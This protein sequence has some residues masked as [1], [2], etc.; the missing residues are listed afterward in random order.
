MD[1]RD[2]SENPKL[3]PEDA[4]AVD[5]WIDGQ[6]PEPG[7]DRSRALRDLLAALDTA[8]TMGDRDARVRSTLD[9]LQPDELSLHPDL[10]EAI[11]GRMLGT[12]TPA[13]LRGQSDG[14]EEIGALL[15]S[16]SAPPG[17]DAASKVARVDR[18]MSRIERD[19]SEPSISDLRQIAEA[20]GVPMSLLFAHASAPSGE[21]GYIVRAGARRPMGSGEE[22]MIEAF[23]PKNRGQSSGTPQIDL[24]EVR[25][26]LL[27]YDRSGRPTKVKNV[28]EGGCV[29]L[30]VGD[31]MFNSAGELE[32]FTIGGRNLP[33]KAP[34]WKELHS[35]L[36][37]FKK[38]Y[39]GSGEKGLPVI[40]DARKQVPTKYVI[41]TLNEVV[42]AGIQDVTFAAPEIP[43]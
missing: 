18:V 9:H 38:G 29:V 3:H 33:E 30:K 21:Q 31:E 6:A 8:P 5:R 14:L 15:T 1:D 2:P 26:K 19:L 34:I 4:A 17:M 22:G 12:K 40:I 36:V 27:W 16:V 32:D 24:N 25:I 37:A 28:R 23:L 13:S 11:D 20:L 41:S 43:Y 7:D 39:S 42:R 35:K 10:I